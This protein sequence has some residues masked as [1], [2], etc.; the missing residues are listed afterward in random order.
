MTRLSETGKFTHSGIP[1]HT[2]E[3]ID[4]IETTLQD[5]YPYQPMGAQENQDLIGQVMADCKELLRFTQ[6]MVNFYEDEKG[7]NETKVEVII[8]T[9]SAVD[10]EA[11]EEAFMAAAIEKGLI[12]LDKHQKKGKMTDLS[13][14]AN[15][16]TGYLS[17]EGLGAKVVAE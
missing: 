15:F 3:A 12:A 11:K 8:R 4:R 13:S 16:L 17:G 14:A 7:A 2:S 6:A 9:V 1:E 10:R 5:C